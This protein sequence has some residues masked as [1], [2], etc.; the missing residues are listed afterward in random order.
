MWA[1]SCAQ[2]T[3]NMK[4]ASLGLSKTTSTKQ[5]IWIFL[6]HPTQDPVM[7]ACKPLILI[8]E[9][10]RGSHDLTKEP[11]TKPNM[12]DSEIIRAGAGVETFFSNRGMHPQKELRPINIITMFYLSPPLF[13][14]MA[15]WRMWILFWGTFTMW[16][17]SSSSVEASGSQAHVAYCKWW[18]PIMNVLFGTDWALEDCG[19]DPLQ[20]TLTRNELGAVLHPNI[21]PMPIVSNAYP[22]LHLNGVRSF[23]ISHLCL[24]MPTC[25]YLCTSCVKVY[26]NYFA[27]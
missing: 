25:T 7:V 2:Y 5:H 14:I 21:L 10:T 17:C 12:Q 6:S 24:S 8:R 3:S 27:N 23:C 1:V 13:A 18:L 15:I 19:P 22:I 9:G 20:L 11:V 16:C 26:C 4:W